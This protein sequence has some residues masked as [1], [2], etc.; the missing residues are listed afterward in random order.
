VNV[1]IAT[2][3]SRGDTQP[4]LAL[5]LGLQRAGHR[6]VL[7]APRDLEGWIGSYGVPVRAMQ[8]HVQ[9]FMHRPEIAAL[10][11]GRNLVRQLRTVG[12]VMDT[13]IGGALDDV[14]EAAQDADFLLL[15]ITEFGGADIAARLGIPMAY[16]SFSPM[17]PPTRSFPSFFLPFRISGSG[18]FNR[19]T[20]E[21]FLRGT[22]PFLGG[23][24]NR[25]R[26]A[27]FGSPPYRSM[28]EMLECRRAYGTPWLFAYSPAVLPK[29][30]DWEDVH[31]LTGYWF[32]DPPPDWRPPEDLAG[33]GSPG[34]K[35]HRTFSS[36]TTCRTAGSFRG[37]PRWCTTEA[38]EP[39]GRVCGPACPA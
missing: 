18:S 21:L 15:P 3:G 2:F 8:F 30:P 11:K 23:P 19:L 4:Q 36:W 31:H 13:L 6:A 24:F 20:Y 35:P 1:T 5:A 33:A 32:L 29:P 22:W 38:R 27:R 9:E 17:Y 39:P 16:V 12:R 34:W 28:R 25:W 37:W 26:A 10:L 14:L 7:V